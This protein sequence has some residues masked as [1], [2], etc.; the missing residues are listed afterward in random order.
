MIKIRSQR[1]MNKCFNYKLHSF[2]CSRSSNSYYKISFNL[3]R[4]LCSK[5]LTLYNKYSKRCKNKINNR[6]FKIKAC[7]IKIKIN[8][9]YKRSSIRLNR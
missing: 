7:L 8:Y 4:R 3:N 9:N 2:N 6:K 5:C 1:A